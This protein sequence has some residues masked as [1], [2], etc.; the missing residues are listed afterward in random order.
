MTRTSALG[1]VLALTLLFA[2]PVAADSSPRAGDAVLRGKVHVLKATPYNPAP[3]NLLFTKVY[4]SVQR[5]PDGLTRM[6][7]THAFSGETCRFVVKHDAR[8]RLRFIEQ[9]ACRFTALS[10]PGTLSVTDGLAFERAGRMHLESTMTIQWLNYTGK[11]RL[12]VSGPAAQ[13]VATNAPP[14]TVRA[15]A[16]V[17]APAASKPPTRRR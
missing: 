17:P 1:A 4:A 9:K 15:E 5:D 12:E 3:K 7:L 2:T 6:T 14:E 13:A 8:G 11:I 10:S 16:P